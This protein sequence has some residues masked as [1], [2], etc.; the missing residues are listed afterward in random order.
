MYEKVKKHYNK[1][2]EEISDKVNLNVLL[3]RMK[4]QQKIDKKN[5]LILSVAAVSAVSI[6]G[7]ILTL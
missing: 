7:L 6:L 1:Q 4:N 3:N 5:N 2:D